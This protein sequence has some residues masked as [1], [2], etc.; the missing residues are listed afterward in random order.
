MQDEL[1]G[2]NSDLE[3]MLRSLNLNEASAEQLDLSQLMAHIMNIDAANKRY[4][5]TL[6]V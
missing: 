3:N 6:L 4:K 1:F 2:G 5:V